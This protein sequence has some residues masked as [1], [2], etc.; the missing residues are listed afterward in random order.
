MRF[1]VLLFLLA[2]AVWALAATDERPWEPH[3]RTA[4]YSWSSAQEWREQ[5]ASFLK[6]AREGHIDM[7]LLGD[8]ITEGW[9]SA[10]EVWN[11]HFAGRQV[12]NFGISGDT[13]QNLL[14][15]ITEGG[16]LRGLSPKAVVLLVGTNNLDL[17]NDSAEDI[18]RGIAAIVQV[19]RQSLPNSKVLILGIFPRGTTLHAELRQRINQTNH[20]IARLADDTAV[21]FLDIGTKFVSENGDLSPEVMPD[22]VHLSPKGYAIWADAMQPVLEALIRQ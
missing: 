5:H 12:A 8:S 19:L 14:W 2:D 20:A 17:R 13:T 21:H 10:P 15:R 18:A 3:P 7:L 9:D 22:A 4:D 11:S 16:E 6:Q 1:A